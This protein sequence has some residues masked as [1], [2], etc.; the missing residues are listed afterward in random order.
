[1]QR[2]FVQGGSTERTNGGIYYRQILPFRH[3]KEWFQER[4]IEVTLG[5]NFGPEI[6]YDAYFFQRTLSL[7]YLS[8]IIELKRQDKMLIWDIDDDLWC[9]PIRRKQDRQQDIKTRRG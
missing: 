3:F 9:F 6:Q 5:G 1:M 2:W 4:E 8:C 7:A